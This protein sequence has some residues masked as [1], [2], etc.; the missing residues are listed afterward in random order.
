MFERTY[1]LLSLHLGVLTLPE[2]IDYYTFS[3]FLPATIFEIN[4]VSLFAS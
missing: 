2:Y 1:N 4:E 3:T